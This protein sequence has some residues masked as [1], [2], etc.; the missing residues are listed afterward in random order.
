MT[1]D[2]DIPKKHKLKFWTI[3]GYCDKTIHLRDLATHVLKVHLGVENKE[4]SDS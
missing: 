2:K 1:T 4:F 3:C